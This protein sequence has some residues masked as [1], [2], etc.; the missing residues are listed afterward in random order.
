[1]SDTRYFKN[2]V[3]IDRGTVKFR[4]SEK[5]TKIWRNFHKEFTI[6]E[7]KAFIDKIPKQDISLQTISIENR[8]WKAC[9]RLLILAPFYAST[10]M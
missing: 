9:C 8:T 1:M 5:A 4:L 3:E 7:K 2:Q 10:K 6:R